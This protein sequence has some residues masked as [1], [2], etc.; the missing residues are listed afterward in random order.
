L[1]SEKSKCCTATSFEKFGDKKRREKGQL[2]KVC[3]DSFDAKAIVTHRF[4]MQKINYLPNHPLS[5]KWM[6]AK[7]LLNMNPAVLYFT[8]YRR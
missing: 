3:K 1:V 5:G 7:N 2:H 4:L 8:C 6:L